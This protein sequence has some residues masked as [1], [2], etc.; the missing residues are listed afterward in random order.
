MGLIRTG[1]RSPSRVLFINGTATGTSTDTIVYGQGGY[2]DFGLVQVTSGSTKNMS[3]RV[4]GNIGE[5]TTWT[6]LIAITTGS[7]SGVLVN[8]TAG[9]IVDRLR[10]NSTVNLTTST[11]HKL[12]VF[13]V[14]QI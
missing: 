10:L 5:S 7:T 13:I 4:E 14:P 12:S 8:T 2:S 1:N 9:L 3:F 6:S 11:G